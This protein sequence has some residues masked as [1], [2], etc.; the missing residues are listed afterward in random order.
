MEGKKL[1]PKN[2]GLG[3]DGISWGFNHQ[4]EGFNIQQVGISWDF[5]RDFMGSKKKKYPQQ[6]YPRANCHIA[7][8]NHYF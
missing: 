1:A 5:R 4:Q 2:H 8:E 6:V 3:W 7:M